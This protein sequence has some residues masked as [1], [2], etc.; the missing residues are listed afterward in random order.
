MAETCTYRHA[1][2]AGM[3]YVN[4][5]DVSEVA[6]VRAVECEDCETVY[7]ECHRCDLP[8]VKV[9]SVWVVTGTDSTADGLSYCPPNPD[10]AG[11]HGAHAPRKV[12]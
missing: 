6:K 4:N 8:I 9:G 7:R 5:E 1:W 12:A 2:V 3:M 11:H 10:H